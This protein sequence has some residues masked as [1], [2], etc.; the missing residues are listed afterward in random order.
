MLN[1]REVESRISNAVRD[2]GLRKGDFL[3][4]CG[5]SINALS[6][7]PRGK[8]MACSTIV[9]MADEL[10]C[11]V[12]YLLGRTDAEGNSYVPSL[13]RQEATLLRVYRELDL[14]EQGEVI[15]IIREKYE[16]G[17]PPTQETH[18]H[19]KTL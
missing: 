3:K 1:M 2:K 11:S 19:E 15:Q 18:K 6:H 14:F 17:T 8:D 7:L 5:L 4:R 10:G 13:T 12:D 16:A 9:T